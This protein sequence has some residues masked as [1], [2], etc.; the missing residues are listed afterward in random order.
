MKCHRLFRPMPL[1]KLIQLFVNMV[2]LAIV[3]VLPLLVGLDVQGQE[4]PRDE[5]LR[6][7]PL[8]YPK[9]VRQTEA[10][11]EL[12][13]FGN[14]EDPEYQDTNPVDGI[15]DRRHEVLLDLAVQ[16]SPLLVFNS[17]MIP[18]DFRPFME[19]EKTFRL[20]VDKWNVS[21]DPPELLN[22]QEIDWQALSPPTSEAGSRAA[23]ADLQLLSLFEEFDPFLPGT[24][25]RSSAVGPG[26]TDHKVMFFNFPGDG[27][28]TWKQEY[29]NQ[30]S[31]ALPQ[32][33]EDFAKVFVHPFVESVDS[34]YRGPGAYEFVLQY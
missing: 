20:F 25:Y 17:T 14:K 18:M 4:I 2:I 27:E 34:R 13:L 11:A 1:M 9:I 24:A 6:Y 15:G 3:G 23:D 26:R 7:L 19:R 21:I 22:S 29:V 10:N 5:Y 33:Y 8:K 16:F 32:A 30:I 31:K 12:H 28:E